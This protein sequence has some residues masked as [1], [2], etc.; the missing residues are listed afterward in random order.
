MKIK[1]LYAE[2]D[3][4]CTGNLKVRRVKRVWIQRML[5]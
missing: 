2:D 3:D 1:I 5:G 4:V